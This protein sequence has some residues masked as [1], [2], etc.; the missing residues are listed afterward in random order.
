MGFVPDAASM[1]RPTRSMSASDERKWAGTERRQD[2]AD[3]VRAIRPAEPGRTWRGETGGVHLSGLQACLRGEQSGAIRSPAHYR[4]RPTAEETAS[5]QA[6][7]PLEDA[8]PGGA[9]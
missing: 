9:G 5:N 7:N 2:S 1:E 4:R 6:G 3:P 8:R